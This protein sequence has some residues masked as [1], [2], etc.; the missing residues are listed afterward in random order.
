MIRDVLDLERLRA[1]PADEA[2]ALLAVRGSDGAEALDEPILAAWLRLDPAHAQ[3]WSLAQRALDC[4]DVDQGDPMLDQL[5]REARAVRDRRAWP[6]RPAVAA[7]AVL[8]LVVGGLFGSGLIPGL[9]ERPAGVEKA[10]GTQLGAPLRYATARGMPSTVTLAD[11]TAMVLDAETA[12]TVSYEKSSRN[13][14]LLKG[15]ASFDVAHNAQRPFAVR[16]GDLAVLAIGTRFDVRLAARRVEVVL[17]EGKVGVS[18]PGAPTIMLKP[19]QIL[20]S[21][22]GAPPRVS[23]ADLQKADNWRLGLLT[24]DDE[25]LAAAAAELNRYNR[26]QIVVRDPRVARMKVSGVFKAGDAERFATA[27]AQVQPVRVVRRGQNEI[28]LAA[29]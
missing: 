1:M 13:V 26:E 2:A 8:I 12:V 5:R 16:A 17:L 9:S 27:L 28:E 22:P 29:R 6:W 24:F 23:S 3:A 15:R 4:F 14:R 25:T 20:V 10:P 18:G 21:D 11:G 7:A 19:G